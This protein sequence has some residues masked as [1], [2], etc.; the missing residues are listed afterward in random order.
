ME[1]YS[2]YSVMKGNISIHQPKSRALS[3]AVLCTHWIHLSCMATNGDKGLKRQR[4]PIDQL[5]EAKQYDIIFGIVPGAFLI[6]AMIIVQFYGIT[7]QLYTK[8]IESETRI[9]ES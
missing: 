3:G 4:I 7:K 1:R 5:V 2:Q 8:L 9:E 6:I